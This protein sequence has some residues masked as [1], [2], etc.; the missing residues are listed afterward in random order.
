MCFD[1]VAVIYLLGF[2]L[3]VRK[4]DRQTGRQTNRQAGGTIKAEVLVL[5]I[6]SVLSEGL[7]TRSVPGVFSTTLFMATPSVERRAFPLPEDTESTLIECYSVHLLSS[8]MVYNY[9]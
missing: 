1:A 9:Y 5:A 7:L 3:R 2:S 8:I 4:V 6:D